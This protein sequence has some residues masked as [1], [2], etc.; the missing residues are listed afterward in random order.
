MPQGLP[1]GTKVHI[2]S[3]RYAGC[4]GTVDAIVSQKTVDYP[5][6]YALGYQV[7]LEDRVV[8]VKQDQVS[9]V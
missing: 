5:E 8:T 9:Q 6:E 4:L 3:G 2:V 1:R 7:V